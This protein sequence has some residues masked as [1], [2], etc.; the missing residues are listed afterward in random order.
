M[1]KAFIRRVKRE[2]I[3]D[4]RRYRYLGG[5]T[6]GGEYTISRLPIDYLDRTVALDKSNWKVVYREK[7]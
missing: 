3:V 1:T 2:G 4:T 6:E 5:E 7:H